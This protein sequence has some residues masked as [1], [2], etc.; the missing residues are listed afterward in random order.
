MCFLKVHSGPLSL[1]K[2]PRTDSNIPAENRHTLI[3]SLYDHATFSPP[4]EAH[5]SRH[6]FRIRRRV[7]GLGDLLRGFVTY[8]QDA[9]HPRW[10]SGDGESV[11][12]VSNC[13]SGLSTAD[14]QRVPQRA[15]PTR[16]RSCVSASWPGSTRPYSGPTPCCRSRR[17]A[18]SMQKWRQRYRIRSHPWTAPLSMAHKNRLVLSYRSVTTWF[19]SFELDSLV[20]EHVTFERMCVLGS[21]AAPG[22]SFQV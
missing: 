22:W 9:R 1:L 18:F 8:G 10:G 14:F 11:R 4:S 16:S 15:C 19:S 2:Q 13:M 20:Q 3:F 17:A 12:P 21:W 5:R 7:D 6:L